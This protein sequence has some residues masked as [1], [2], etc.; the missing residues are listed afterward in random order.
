MQHQKGFCWHCF[1][2]WNF[3]LWTII[4]AF[5]A[6]FL[7]NGGSTWVLLFVFAV[8]VMATKFPEG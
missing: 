3:P 4:S 2:T 6:I 5:T 7:L 8:G 1:W